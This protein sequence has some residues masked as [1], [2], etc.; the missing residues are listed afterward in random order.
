MKCMKKCHNHF[1][2]IYYFKSN[3]YYW[4]L[5]NVRFPFARV[6]ESKITLETNPQ[7]TISIIIPGLNVSLLLWGWVSWEDKG[8]KKERI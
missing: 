6:S 7:R 3:G 1:I 4:I 2:I 5:E 8:K